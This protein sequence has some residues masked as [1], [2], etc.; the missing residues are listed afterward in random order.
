MTTEDKSRTERPERVTDSVFHL[1]F[2]APRPVIQEM[3]KF[4]MGE[5]FYFGACP[6][7]SLSEMFANAGCGFVHSQFKAGLLS[8]A[9][10][11]VAVVLH[12]KSK[13]DQRVIEEAKAIGLPILV[14]TSKLAAAVQAGEP[15]ADLYLEEPAS[16]EEVA[17]M[18]MEMITANQQNLKAFACKAGELPVIVHP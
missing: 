7:D 17:T 13:K 1:V 10:S 11:C 8:N 14:I 4:A 5:V 16:N 12:W 3:D 2:R 9:T 6:D 18:L 15:S